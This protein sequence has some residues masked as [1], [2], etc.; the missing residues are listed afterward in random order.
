MEQAHR[1]ICEIDLSQTNHLHVQ[2][3]HQ[4]F[5]L[6]LCKIRLHDNIISMDMLYIQF[7]M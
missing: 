2:I 1:G 3:I 5:D 4:M 6:N 7:Q